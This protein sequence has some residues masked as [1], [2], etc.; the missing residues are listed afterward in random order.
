MALEQGDIIL[1]TVDRIVGTVV[2]VK[3]PDSENPQKQLEGS[4]VFSEVS[5][6]RIRNIRDYVVPK[7]KIVCKILR[8]SQNGH[9][10][11][12][13]R[14]VTQK[15]QKEMLNQFKLEKSYKN[16]LK[17]IINDKNFQEINNKIKKE[18]GN[19]YDFIEK[20]KSNPKEL[21]KLIGKDSTSRLLKIIKEQ[22][23]KKST[24]KKQISLK[25]TLSDGIE[26]IKSILSPGKKQG[27][28]VKYISAG[29]YSLKI[30]SENLKSA[31]NALKDF[32]QEIEK[33][34]KKQNIE[35]SEIENKK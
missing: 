9:I 30:T 32:I 10:D 17:S 23:Q 3:F 16:I 20:S 5:P 7:K 15:E 21:E 33:S 24:I 27:I 22:K 18:G 11:L 26:K 2:F 12:S 13:L 28:E 14:R 31:D 6:G 1:G 8:I 35:F 19:L 29:N 25:T 4:L 34:A